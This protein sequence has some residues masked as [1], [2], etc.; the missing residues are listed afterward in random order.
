MAR[1]SL[2][3]LD[4]TLY[5]SSSWSRVEP[6][7]MISMSSKKLNLFSMFSSVLSKV[8]WNVAGISLRP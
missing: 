1:F 6:F 5:M 2:L 7:V 4:R 3:S 8:V